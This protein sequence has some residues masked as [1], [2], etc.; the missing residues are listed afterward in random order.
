MVEPN[1]ACDPAGNNPSLPLLQ[2]SAE[3]RAATHSPTTTKTLMELDRRFEW[4]LKEKCLYDKGVARFMAIELSY[5]DWVPMG[6]VVGPA[7]LWAFAGL[8]YVWISFLLTP[9]LGM[10]L[11]PCPLKG[12]LLASYPTWIWLFGFPFFGGCAL[13]EWRVLRYAILPLFHECWRRSALIERENSGK[14]NASGSNAEPIAD[15]ASSEI[16]EINTEGAMSVGFFDHHLFGSIRSWVAAISFVSFMNH[17]SIL[18][19][20]LFL[21]KVLKTQECTIQYTSSSQMELDAIWSYV[22]QRSSFSRIPFVGPLIIDELSFVHMVLLVWALMLLQPLYALVTSVP[23]ECCGSCPDYKI[24]WSRKRHEKN[25][26]PEDAKHSFTCREAS[27][28]RIDV[29]NHLKLQYKT[30]TWEKHNHAQALFHLAEGARMASICALRSPALRNYLRRRL[31]GHKHGKGV[32]IGHQELNVLRSINAAALARYV[33][34]GLLENALMLNIQ[35]TTLA[36]FAY[37]HNQTDA[38]MS[39]VDDIHGHWQVYVSVVASLFIGLWKVGDAYRLML[40]TWNELSTGGL[41]KYIG[42][43]NNF[44]KRRHFLRFEVFV[45]L[46][47]VLVFFF[48]I[49]IAVM[50]LLMLHIC[51]D[52]FWNFS[53]TLDQR[54]GCVDMSNSSVVQNIFNNSQWESKNQTLTPY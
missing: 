7:V 10:Q 27:Q 12:Q 53:W 51:R 30:V 34:I 5:K 23:I 1:G 43:E 37:V 3:A 13:F 49:F 2:E 38:T 9:Y 4:A 16:T 44:H 14:E 31:E 22:M 39:T 33:L 11:S 19:N 40:G 21:V 35:I 47:F 6:A 46:V 45:V 24:G 25:H 15:A 36:M 29:E 42:E 41:A 18:S 8:A 48:A 54:N 20:G 52:K 50:K 32:K 28:S 26:V 17:L